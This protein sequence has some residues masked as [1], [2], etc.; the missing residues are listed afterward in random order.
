MDF[1]LKRRTTAGLIV[2]TSTVTRGKRAAITSKIR[3]TSRSER[4]IVSPSMMTSA[5]ASRS[6]TAALQSSIA[7]MASCVIFP[8]SGRS[9]ARTAIV[10]G[11]S[12]LYQW[13]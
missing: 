8:L 6:S 9:S 2:S 13:P 5:G 10:S 12:R 11:R 1:S 7:D 4:Y 3:C